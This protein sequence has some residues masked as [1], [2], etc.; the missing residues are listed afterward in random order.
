M[1][2]LVSGGFHF[3]DNTP[4]GAAQELNSMH[5]CYLTKTHTHTLKNNEQKSSDRQVP[6]PFSLSFFFIHFH[7]CMMET[8]IPVLITV[9]FNDS[10]ALFLNGTLKYECKWFA[11]THLYIVI[12]TAYV[13][14]VCSF[15]NRLV[16]DVTSFSAQIT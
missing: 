8:P 1:R 6:A 10:L 5:D 15:F 11:L 14:C 2:T 7:F 16:G 13:N 12:C 9:A 3:A 4:F